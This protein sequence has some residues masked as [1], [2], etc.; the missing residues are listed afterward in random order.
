MSEIN[1]SGIVK[2]ITQNYLEV[3]VAAGTACDGCHARSVCLPGGDREKI[4]R[5]E[6]NHPLISPG[7]RVMVSMKAGQGFGAVVLAY[8]IPVIVMVTTLFTVIGAGGSDGMAAFS[9][10]SATAI[11]FFIL[12]LLKSRIQRRVI[13]SVRK[14]NIL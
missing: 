8:L 14:E 3:S 7:D 4:I 12:W 13:F 2:K 10:L 11:W 1:H 9:A 5:V 6:G